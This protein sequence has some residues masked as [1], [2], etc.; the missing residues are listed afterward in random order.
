MMTEKSYLVRPGWWSETATVIKR[1]WQA[2]CAMRR[3]NARS[4]DHFQREPDRTSCGAAVLRKKGERWET[5]MIG[6][7]HGHWSFP[8]GHQEAGET[9]EETARRE[10]LE[11]TG[12][13]VRILPGFRKA[14]PTIEPNSQRQIVCFIALYLSGVPVAQENEIGGLAWVA[15]RDAPRRAARYPQDARLF[16]DVIDYLKQDGA[17]LPEGSPA[18]L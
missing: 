4:P 6:S 16:Q 14:L 13:Q 2:L 15:L 5:L 7:R 8:K 11:E 10:I 12:V 3:F 9:E 18:Q 17:G 1:F